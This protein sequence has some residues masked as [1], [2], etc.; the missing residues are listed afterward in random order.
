M[1]TLLDLDPVGNTVWAVGVQLVVGQQGRE[2]VI[3]D[4]RRPDV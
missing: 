1:V 4:E 2:V 3:V